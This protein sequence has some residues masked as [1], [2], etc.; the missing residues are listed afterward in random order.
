M[1]RHVH[2]LAIDDAETPPAFARV[3]TPLQDFD[4][5]F[6]YTP[7][8]EEAGYKSTESFPESPYSHPLAPARGF[9]IGLFLSV[10]LW[11]LIAKALLIFLG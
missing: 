5:C 4:D 2:D 6:I 7:P 3:S 10:I 11:A 1:T 8:M 9:L